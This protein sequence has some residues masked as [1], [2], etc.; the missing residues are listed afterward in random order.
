[1]LAIGSVAPSARYYDRVPRPHTAYSSSQTLACIYFTS[2]VIRSYC[3]YFASHY[4]AEAI[5][6]EIYMSQC[7]FRDWG[8]TDVNHT[9]LD[10]C[11]SKFMEKI[12]NVGIVIIRICIWMMVSGDCLLTLISL[13]D[14]VYGICFLLVFL[15]SMLLMLITSQN[16]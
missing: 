14:A 15:Y 1:M 4:N 11:S 6:S 13:L 2:K 10:H 7:S 5:E 16:F 8:I 9:K 3:G 12:G